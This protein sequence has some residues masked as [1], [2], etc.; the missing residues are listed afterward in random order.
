MLKFDPH[1]VKLIIFIPRA[2]MTKCGD[3][4]R[5]SNCNISDL[6]NIEESVLQWHSFS[7]KA[8]SIFP[9]MRR[10]FYFQVLIRTLIYIFTYILI[11][12]QNNNKHFV[13]Y[14]N[15]VIFYKDFYFLH[16]IWTIVDDK[17]CKN[18]C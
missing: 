13:K 3:E 11:K 6:G 17:R 14:E 15:K 16:K 8:I 18:V 5:Y 2:G 1:S 4:L 12:I 9:F 10:K 7:L